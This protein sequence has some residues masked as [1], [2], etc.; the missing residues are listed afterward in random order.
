MD[1]Q[2]I[3]QIKTLARKEC[4][5]CI[6]GKCMMDHNCHVISP[7]YPSVHDGAID[8]DYFLQCVLPIDPNLNKLVWNE[9]LREEEMEQPQ[10]KICAWCGNPFLPS[11]KR[12]Q[13]CS[14]C[15]PIHEQIRNRNKQRNYNQRKQA[16][17]A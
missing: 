16:K 9:L 12:Q 4:C 13:Y 17:N 2:L 6:D 11:N 8:C 5:N 1:K 3:R 15:K 10:D 14:R 7:R